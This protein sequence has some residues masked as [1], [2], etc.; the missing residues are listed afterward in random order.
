MH[1]RAVDQQT[2]VYLCVDKAARTYTD[3]VSTKSNSRV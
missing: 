1:R 3:F 2:T